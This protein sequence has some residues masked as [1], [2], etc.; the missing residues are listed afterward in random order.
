MSLIEIGGKRITTCDLT[1][2]FKPPAK[3]LERKGNRLE[4]LIIGHDA[5]FSEQLSS[6][7]VSGDGGSQLSVVG[8]SQ[9]ERNTVKGQTQV[10]LL[11]W[12]CRIQYPV[13]HVILWPRTDQHLFHPV[14][15]N[16]SA[17]I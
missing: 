4:H 12:D 9:V 2:L 5:C 13:D 6:I 14:C 11:A 8:V 16:R 7:R 10:E 1:T 17:A 3:R 15:K